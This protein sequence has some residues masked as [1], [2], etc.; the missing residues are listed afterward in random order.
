MKSPRELALD[1]LNRMDEGSYIDSLLDSALS[2]SGLPG[3][4][5]SRAT[6]LVFGVVRW[7]DLID[8][9]I[10]RFARGRVDPIARNILRMAVFQLLFVP[11]VPP[12]VV[13]NESVELA[14]RRYRRAAG[15]INGVL[16][17]VERNKGDLGLPNIE[18]D[19]VS[20]IAIGYSHPRWMVER[21][22]K[23]W[24]VDET[25]A[26][27]SANNRVPPLCLRA[28][29]LKISRGDLMGILRG[30]GV[31]CRESVR[32]PE[33][34]IVLG[35]L[36]PGEDEA[37]RRGLYYVQDEASIIVSH[38]LDPKPGE[39]ILD[40]CSAPG[41]KA[42]HIA[43]LMGDRGR[44]IAVD[45]NASRVALIEENCR[46]LGV[47]IVETAVADG[48]EFRMTADRVLVDAPCSALGILRRKA[49]AK[50]HRSESD[51]LGLS[52]I[53]FELLENAGHC[54]RAGGILVY[55]VCTLEEEEN[56]DVVRRFLD[57]N[58]AF[59]PAAP[60]LKFTP[61]GDDCDG[62]FIAKLVKKV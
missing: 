57:Q 60:P 44:V 45:R 41:G 10:D 21:W 15:Y 28:N 7:R 17:S 5:R 8:Y 58:P 59:A 16:R 11:E 53:Q 4:E 14:K 50:W 12:Y 43:A 2:S 31:S 54:L 38:V 49:D 13:V 48:R 37:F 46:R 35:N 51:I 36:N 30:K 3:D 24:G 55:S 22:V 34:I 32:A 1:I 23:R 25:L 18:A 20:H 56:E 52:Q 47:S 42:T 40:L 39:T 6:K 29:T 61:H 33:G 62:F 19:P 27:C 26:I 9:E